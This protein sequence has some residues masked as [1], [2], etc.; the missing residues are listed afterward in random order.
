MAKGGE[1]RIG[2]TLWAASMGRE[3]GIERRREG[4]NKGDVSAGAPRSIIAALLSLI[5]RN[6]NTAEGRRQRNDVK[7]AGGAGGGRG[8]AA[9]PQMR[10][11][12]METRKKAAV[13]GGRK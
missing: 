2:E 10:R 6:I 8:G 5:I 12:G 3:S 13:S 9:P 11:R 7:S 4:Q 1:P